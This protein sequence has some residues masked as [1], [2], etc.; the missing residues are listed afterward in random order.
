M[1][2]LYVTGFIDEFMDADKPMEA[3]G[4]IGRI[5]GLAGEAISIE[6][7]IYQNTSDEKYYRTSASGK[8]TSAGFIALAIST[9]ASGA[10]VTGQHIGGYYPTGING[11]GTFWL[12]LN[13]GEITT[14]APTGTGQVLRPFGYSLV[15]SGIMVAPDPTFAV[16]GDP[17]AV[18]AHASNHTDGTDD[19]QLA[20]SSQKGLMPSGD[21]YYIHQN[22]GI[23]IQTTNYQL[24]LGDS[25]KTIEMNVASVN[26]VTIP[27]NATT[28]FPIGTYIDIVQYG[29]GLTSVTGAGGVTVNG[30]VAGGV[31][32]GGQYY[33]ASIYKRATDEWI[34]I[35]GA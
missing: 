1:P 2:D 10:V 17:T 11:T 18:T 23:N 24:V 20:T 22:T 35:G 3:L 30:T 32:L 31:D 9:A 29:T 5:T 34:A 25:Y 27:A 13:Q 8:S 4:V 16:I 26:T 15:S 21:S 14:T 33:A 12:G 28:A 6:D 19:I 7:S